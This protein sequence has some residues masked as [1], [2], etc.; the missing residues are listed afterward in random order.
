MLPLQ[1]PQPWM[2]WRLTQIALV[3]AV[4]LFAALVALGNLSDYQSNFLFVQHVLAMDTIFP[5]AKIG[6]RAITA[7]W[8]HHAAYWLIIL[9]ELGTALL[10]GWGAVRLWR[11]RAAPPAAF[12]QAKGV[13]VLGLLLGLLLWFTG[14]ITLGG[15]WFGMWMSSTWNGIASAFRFFMIFAVVLMVLVLRDD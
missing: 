14:F 3:A 7:P 5:D 1:S 4:A 8:L 6:W 13:A 15:E 10:C 12:R 11:R 9:L 2:A